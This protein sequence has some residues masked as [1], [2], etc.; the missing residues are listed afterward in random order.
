MN[1]RIYEWMER[2]NSNEAIF[3]K[4]QSK[5]FKCILFTINRNFS[6]SLRIVCVLLLYRCCHLQQNCTRMRNAWEHVKFWAKRT[7]CKRMDVCLKSIWWA[8]TNGEAMWKLNVW[9][10]TLDVVSVNSAR[11]NDKRWWFLQKHEPNGWLLPMDV[12]DKI[13]QLSRSTQHSAM[14]VL[15]MVGIGHILCDV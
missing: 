10:N 1:E 12:L 14:M 3:I 5:P 8:I 15:F 4:S 11:K 9:P 6:L 2:T 7:K 13:F